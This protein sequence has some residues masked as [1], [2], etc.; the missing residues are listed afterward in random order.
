MMDYFRKLPGFKRSASGLER[1][2]LRKLP[3]L[4]LLGT[5]L[6]AG[7]VLLLDLSEML[8]PAVLDKTIIFTIALVILYWTF[9][10]VIG[11]A[12]FIIMVMKGPAYVADPYYPPDFKDRDDDDD[13][14]REL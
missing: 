7:F 1:Q 5:L 9:M 6:P 12:A 2:V 14:L 13:S 4:L 11:F 3:L 8:E 10:L